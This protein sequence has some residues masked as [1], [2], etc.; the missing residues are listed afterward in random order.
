MRE[1]GRLERARETCVCCVCGVC[2]M[3]V[4]RVHCVCVCHV[5]A[6]CITC[7]CVSITCVCVRVYSSVWS[8]DSALLTVPNCSAV[9]HVCHIEE[10]ME[11]IQ[12][13]IFK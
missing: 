2:C 10:G 3:R 5:C 13:S 1:R 4:C 7:V 6:A 11:R 9:L 12:H 8:A